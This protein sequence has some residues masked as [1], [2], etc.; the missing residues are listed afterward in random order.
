MN[1]Y[2]NKAQHKPNRMHP[3]VAGAAISVMLASLTGVAA[4]TG[5]LPNSHGENK[6]AAEAAQPQ[7]AQS[8]PEKPA[9]VAKTPKA[10]SSDKLAL[11]EE[12]EAP[13]SRQQPAASWPSQQN[14]H[15]APDYTQ[16]TVRVA[17]PARVCGNCGRIESVHAVQTPAD[18]SGV[19]VVG[20]AVV[21]GLLGNQIGGGSGKTLATIAGAVGGG[22]AGNEVEKRTRTATSYQVRVRMENGQVR[23]FPYNNQPPWHQ[24]DRV[25][26]V[27]GYLQAA[28]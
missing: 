1:I 21:G 2:N 18:P 17:Q 11:R 22:Y 10:V 7:K 12:E 20:G 5:L 4:M 24:G 8:T 19:G 14:S 28:R 9:A 26:V 6:A 25:R 27:D 23:N 3:L 13:A 16:D 15:G